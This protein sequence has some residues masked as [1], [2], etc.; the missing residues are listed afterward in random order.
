MNLQ[1]KYTVYLWIFKKSIQCTDESSRK[2]YSLSMN[3]QEKYTVYLWIFMIIS[4]IWKNN[5]ANHLT[6]G[7]PRSTQGITE[8]THSPTPCT[9]LKFQ[10]S[11]TVFQ[12]FLYMVSGFTLHFLPCWWHWSWPVTF[13]WLGNCFPGNPTWTRCCIFALSSGG[14]MGA[15]LAVKTG[16]VKLYCLVDC[17]FF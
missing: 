5:I 3:L 13:D 8:K 9:H 15:F 14:G 11:L 17:I 2:V 4:C 6:F 1:E 16:Y 12:V 10:D 7:Q